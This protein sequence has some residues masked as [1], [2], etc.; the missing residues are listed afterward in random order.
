MEW[1]TL[2]AGQSA[3]LAEE[4]KGEVPESSG[5]GSKDSHM[6]PFTALA[7]GQLLSCC[8]SE[9]IHPSI[10]SFIHCLECKPM[11]RPLLTAVT[12]QEF[13]AA[14]QSGFTLVLG[15]RG[16]S[17]RLW[18]AWTG[19]QDKQ[20]HVLGSSGYTSIQTL[21]QYATYEKTIQDWHVFAIGFHIT[22]QGTCSEDRHAS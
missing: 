21:H 13:S 8:L 5:D 2:E 14:F 11:R 3:N 19:E 10:H 1:A 16:V 4:S 7:L 17:G 9:A 6:E 22:F 15:S 12:V 20:S 18:Y